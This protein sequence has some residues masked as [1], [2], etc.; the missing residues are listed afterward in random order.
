MQ[1]VMENLDEKFFQRHITEYLVE[2]NPLYVERKSSDFDLEAMCDREELLRF[3]RAQRDSWNKLC[4]KFDGEQAAL[5]AVIKRYNERLDN[6]SIINL[7]NGREDKQFKIKGVP[8]KLVQYRPQLVNNEDDEFVQLYKQNRFAVVREFRYSNDPKDS[9]NRIDLVFLINGLPIMTCELKNELSSTHWTYLDAIEQYQNDRDSKNQFLKTC[10]VHFAVDN[11]YAFMTTHLAGEQTHFLPFNRF[12]TNPPIEGDY[13]TAYLWQDIWQAD[14]LLNLLENYIKNYD[15]T[16]EEGHTTNVTVF[17]R[18]HQLRAVN[19]LVRWSKENGAG[20]NYLIEHSAGSGKTKSMAWLAHQLVN[21]FVLDENGNKKKV[22]D[23]IIMVTDRI[24]L[25]ANMADDVNYF[26]NVAGLVKDI[27]KGSRNLADAIDEGGQIIICTVQKFSYALATLKR[28][29]KRRYAVIVDEAH[30]AIGSESAKDI[31]QALSTDEEVTQVLKENEAN[32]EGAVDALLSYMQATRQKMQH[33]SFFA[34]TATPKD[35]T[36]ALFGRPKADGKGNGVAHDLYSMRQAI[37]EKFILDVLQNYTTYQT[38]FKYVEKEDEGKKYEKKKAIRL[39]MKQLGREPKTMR[40][41]ASFVVTHFMEKTIHQINGTAKAMFVTESREAVVRYKQLVDGFINEKYNGKIKTLAAFSGEIEVDGKKYTEETLNG[42]GIKD[43]GIRTTFKKP[44]YKILIAA[45]KFQTGFDQKLL[46]TMYVDKFLDGIQAIQTLSRLNR[47]CKDKEDTLVIDFRNKKEDIK[48]SFDKY[49]YGASLDGEFEPERLYTYRSEIRNFKLYSAN[50]VSNVVTLLLGDKNDLKKVPA[51]LKKI[52]DDNIANLDNDKKD[53]LR[54]RVKRYIRSYGFLAQLMDFID[55]DLEKEYLFLKALYSYLPYTKDTLPMEVLNKIDLD[56]VKVDHKTFEGAIKMEKGDA[57]T[58]RYDKIKKKLEDDKARLSEIL[59]IVNKQ[60]AE[61]F[62]QHEATIRPITIEVTADSGLR[63]AFAADNNY[64]DLINKLKETVMDKV[65]NHS[66]DLLD[67]LSKI[68]TNS[69]IG[70]EYIEKLYD[71]LADSTREEQN[72]KLDIEL[73]KQKLVEDQSSEFDPLKRWIRPLPEIIDYLIK[74]IQADSLPK[75]DGANEL[76]LDSLNIVYCSDKLRSVDRRRHFNSLVSKYEVFLKKL[77]YLINNQEITNQEGATESTFTNAVFAFD[78][79]RGLKYNRDEHYTNFKNYIEM[80][81][82]WRNDEAHLA[83]N[84][85][86]Q[87]IITATHILVTM[88]VFVISQNTTELEDVLD[89]LIEPI[90]PF[91]HTPIL[92]RSAEEEQ[93]PMAAEDIFIYGSIPVHLPKT[94]RSDLLANKLDLVLMYA[95]GTAA[96]KKTEAAGK[97]ALGIKEEMLSDEQMAAYQSAKYLLFHYWSNPKCF[98]LLKQPVL[99]EPK[100]VPDDYLVRMPKGAVK[101]LLLEYNPR[102]V[103]PMGNIDLSKTQR[104]GVIKY[105]P[106]VTT[107][108]SI[109][110]A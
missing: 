89:G 62:N 40:D 23:S 31:I 92:Y 56:K 50:D 85:D 98:T 57:I 65:G 106:F 93:L 70:R 99:V 15:E 103:E 60:S 6:E 87:E 3:L 35:K 108:E 77:Y 12:T 18:Y 41:K 55:T 91:G 16:D 69:P 7:L 59:D 13:A 83:P 2:N 101:F 19:N 22:Y 109:T 74:A 28:E 24:I 76:I 11:N 33:I 34:F 88:Y 97:I 43:D 49:H 96:R 36:Y 8:L 38:Q 94:N 100:D 72:F 25:N 73:L 84:S 105:L 78:C 90:I 45:D 4:R 68:T 52:V 95:I 71:Y 82:Q 54:K 39:I 110:E 79:L 63:D 67:F 14:S 10:L 21:T 9:G 42:D 17:P 32:Y 53:E 61:Y 51:I 86:V 81:R 46:H 102:E 44:E 37:D 104:H 26:N 20:T 58:P 47:T 48:A 5:E 64:N 107:I 80:V 75:L 66:D 27:R 1:A 29:K 30:T